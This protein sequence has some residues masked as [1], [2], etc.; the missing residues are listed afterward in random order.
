MSAGPSV[1]HVSAASCKVGEKGSIGGAHMMH[2]I[3]A[4]ASQP[5]RSGALQSTERSTRRKRS[6]PANSPS[7][8]MQLNVVKILQFKDAV[9]ASEGA[10]VGA[11]ASLVC[12]SLLGGDGRVNEE[13]DVWDDRGSN[14]GLSV[15]RQ[16]RA[17]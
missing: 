6:E 4:Y 7:K 3:T 17:M 5:P 13:H 15:K 16:V 9:K 1:P 10:F 8:V 11:V 12:I 2:M 14:A